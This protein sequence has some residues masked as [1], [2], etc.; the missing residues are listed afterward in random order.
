MDYSQ[1]RSFTVNNKNAFMDMMEGVLAGKTG[2]TADAGYCYVAAVEK[3]GKT[4]IVALLGCGWPNNKNYKWQ[5][6]KKLINYAISNFNIKEIT[7]KNTPMKTI[8]V[9]EGTPNIQIN[10]YISDYV[11]FLVG[12]DEKVTLKYNI[13]G[14]MCP[15][16]KKGD[17]VGHIDIYINNQYMKTINVYAESSTYEKDYKYYYELIINTIL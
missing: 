4:Y 2:F 10:T 11:S 17:I 14:V 6:T 5:D 8:E 12:N 1:K 3:D 9:P 16:I 15:P 7:D 13:P